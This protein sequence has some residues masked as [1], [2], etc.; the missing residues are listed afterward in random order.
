MAEEIHNLEERYEFA[1]STKKRLMIL[2]GVGLA[3][4]I[5]GIM[6]V[7]SGA[8]SGDGGHAA[9]ISVTSSDQ[10]FIT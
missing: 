4:V 7:M 3:L 9:N 1:S 2:I 5:A 6:Q 8:D 10:S